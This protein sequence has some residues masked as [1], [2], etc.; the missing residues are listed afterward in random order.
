[1]K[2]FHHLNNFY[3]Y[4]NTDSF[5]A[6]PLAVII[7]Y[8]FLGL[9]EFCLTLSL[10]EYYWQLDLAFVLLI[11]ESIIFRI[12]LH[13]QD[14][15]SKYFINR[16]AGEQTWCQVTRRATKHVSHLLTTQLNLL[17]YW[18][19]WLMSTQYGLIHKCPEEA[20]LSFLWELLDNSSV[21]GNGYK[22]WWLVHIN[23]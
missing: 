20:D 7:V 5:N 3:G 15:F 19:T 12:V 17:C 14:V 18:I 4:H 10:K 13:T 22:D 6:V 23:D 11:T 1:M 8:L 21:R 9:I 16:R 2:M